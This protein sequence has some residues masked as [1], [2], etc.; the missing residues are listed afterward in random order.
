MKRRP[1]I[2]IS[3]LSLMSLF[4]RRAAG[5]EKY[6]EQSPSF[7]RFVLPVLSKAGCNSGA[8]H[9]Y[10][11][12]RGGFKLSLRGED[13]A[14]DYRAI[15]EDLAERRIHR[16]SADLSLLLLKP[17]AQVP[18]EGGQRFALGSL[19]HRLLSAWINA[20][21]PQPDEAASLAQLHVTPQEK[22]VFAPDDT[23]QLDVVA[24]F[25]DGQ[26]LNVT[27]LAVYEVSTT[28]AEVTAGGLVQRK[29][30]G[31][32][33]V[34]VRFL[35]GQQAVRLAFMPERPA[36]EFAAPPSTNYIDKHLF[37]KLKKLRIN[38][39]P[40]C[41]DEVFV[42]RA[43]LDAIGVMPSADE[44]RSLVADANPDKRARLIDDLLMRPEFGDYWALKWSDILRNEEKTLDA[45]GVEVFHAWIRDSFNG[46]KPLDEFCRELIASRGSTYKHPPANFWRAL[47]DPSTRA[48]TTA[49]VFL[50]VRLQCAKCH[51]HPTGR[52][53]QDDYYSWSAMFARI[54][55]KI[56]KNKR[57][58]KFDKHEFDGEQIVLVKDTGE[59]KNPRTSSNA[60]A[61]FLGGDSLDADAKADRLEP[62]AQW[63]TDPDNPWFARAQVNRI[64]YH[65][66]GRG[67]IE[68]IDDLRV[69]NPPISE[70]L[71]AA[72]TEDFVKS[73]FN[74]RHL[75]RRIMNSQAYQVSSTPNETN[76]DDE[77]N[78]SRAVVQRLPAELLL[79]AQ[80]DFLGAVPEFN[81][82]PRG[83]R[84][85]QLAGVRRVRRRDKS[86]TDDDR[87]LMQFGKPGRLLSCECERSNETTLPHAMTLIC[88]PPIQH[89]IEAKGNRLAKLADSELSDEELFD[90]LYWAAISRAPNQEELEAM[91]K[92]IAN[93]ET[94]LIALQDIAW[95][96]IN[97]KEF[98]FR[99]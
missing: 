29:A 30:F 26:R 47:R 17:T 34:L 4:V 23:V 36:F 43:Y 32:T 92:H 57:A 95:A 76:G 44:A 22:V 67:L 63:M 37:A 77:T 81:G 15:V 46:G 74:V 54:D 85:V 3:L 18:H 16:Q 19:E 83:T 10:R 20:G 64:W 61:K 2:L 6:F 73:D 97:S 71:M 62:A 69:T 65:V 42:R 80:C 50:G 21:A 79:D 66:M 49:R 88:G 40:P 48:E 33:T 55:Y 24:E 98:V 11:E 25:A 38:P 41:S 5:D 59:V 27:P 87:F 60:A 86:P 75:I 68:P 72:L 28:S 51:N 89:R 91:K 90:E 7:E 13:P 70:P 39:S 84:A 1:L 78:F 99:H 35:G 58:D 9:G 96:L 12:G 8:C 82:Y 94:R 93:S 53:T 52:W 14:A 31:E 56:V 45:R